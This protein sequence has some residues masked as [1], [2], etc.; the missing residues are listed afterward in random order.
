MSFR[1]QDLSVLAYANGFTHWHYRTNDT[2][3]ILLAGYF[4]G[5]AELFR[6]GDQISVTLL[7]PGRVDLASLVV[8]AIPEAAAPDLA[9]LASSVTPAS[10]LPATL[11]LVA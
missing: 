3:D 6:P 2:L 8:T 5:A 9:L 7:H 1:A 4:A 11:A 10:L